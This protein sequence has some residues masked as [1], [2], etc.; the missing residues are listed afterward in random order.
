M[1]GKIIKESLSE[2][3]QDQVDN[4]INY[5]NKVLNDED[6]K[7]KK[8]KNPWFGFK[9]DPELITAFKKV[10]IDGLV[11]DGEHVTW[12]KTGVSYDYQAYKN[13]MFI[14]YPES[15]IDL[16]MVFKDDSFKF[17]KESGKVIYTHEIV[18]PFSPEKEKEIV[19]GYCVIKNKRGEFLTT[20]SF[21][22][23][24]KHRKVAKT[25]SIWAKWL[26]EM[27]M[28]TIIKKGCKTHFGD[29]YQNI[30][31]I[32]DENYDLENSLEISVETKQELEKI[33]TVPE[34]NA[35]YKENEG[36]NA[37]IIKDFVKACAD[38]KAQIVDELA[39]PGGSNDD[40]S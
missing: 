6:W 26:L 3:N 22:E 36:K 30:E 16:Q 37:G 17:S 24:K 5:C 39:N 34:L 38:R 4:Y 10:A 11:F 7:T 1:N 28:K 27:C 40:N 14:A 35:Y 21:D 31:T 9:K 32:D 15:I 13:K 2:Y 29:I 20:L 25:D 23:I 19:G 12:I 8:K 18:N 33:K